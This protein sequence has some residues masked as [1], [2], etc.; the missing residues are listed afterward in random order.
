MPFL[1]KLARS[2]RTNAIISALVLSERDYQLY[3]FYCLVQ[4]GPLACEPTG[5]FSRID[6]NL[7]TATLKQYLKG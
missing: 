6:Q 4:L 1:F 3:S 7:S 5:F 2:A